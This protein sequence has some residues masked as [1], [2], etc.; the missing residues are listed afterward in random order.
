MRAGRQERMMLTLIRFI[1]FTS[2]DLDQ[3]PKVTVF[4]GANKKDPYPRHG[5][6]DK[7]LVGRITV[8]VPGLS[9]VLTESGSAFSLAD[10]YSP[11]YVCTINFSM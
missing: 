4:A 3:F 10:N 1:V 6:L 9:T 8:P 7:G 11:L 5:Y 2:D